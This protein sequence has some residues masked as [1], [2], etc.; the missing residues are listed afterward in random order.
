MALALV[1]LAVAGW[2]GSPVRRGPGAGLLVLGAL[3]VVLALAGSLPV[4][5]VL[6][7]AVVTSVPGGGLLRDGQKWAAWWALPLA[8]G[9]GLGARRVAAVVRPVGAA[10]AA[11]ASGVLLLLPVAGLPDS[12]RAT[13]RRS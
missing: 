12:T 8:V 11:V 5:R 4:L 7:E 9:A 6:L 3:G 1:A 13:C 2:R 10:A